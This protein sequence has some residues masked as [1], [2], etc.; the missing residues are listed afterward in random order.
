[1]FILLLLL[2]IV[3]NEKIT[4]EIVLLGMIMSGLVYWFAYKFAGL[5]LKKELLA[6]KRAG[7]ML[8]YVGVL[9]IEIIKANLITIKVIASHRYEIEPVL[10]SFDVHFETQT[11]KV[12]FANSITLTPGTITVDIVEDKYTVHALDVSYIDGINNGKIVEILHRMEAIHD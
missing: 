10:V 3:F 8:E 1:M 4:L 9:C 12:L 6:A 7:Y 11:A 2:W 5:T